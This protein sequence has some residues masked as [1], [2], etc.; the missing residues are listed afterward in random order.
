M[1]LYS[2]R[3]LFF[4][5]LWTAMLIHQIVFYKGYVSLPWIFLGGYYGF[6]CIRAAF[7]KEAMDKAEQMAVLDE[8]ARK[9]LM[10]PFWRFPEGVALALC[11]VGVVA[12]SA[13][14]ERFEGLGQFLL[15]VC[16]VAA[17]VF[18]VWYTARY[19]ELLQQLEQEANGI[20][21]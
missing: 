8:I 5:L 4:G 6:Q 14:W 3:N 13:L 18:A 9:R 2:K 21:E 12:Y 20:I 10:G 11:L 19:R 16:F 7:S 15:I 1:K 17:T